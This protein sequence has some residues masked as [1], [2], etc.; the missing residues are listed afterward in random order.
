MRVLSVLGG[1]AVA[2]MLFAQGDRG[3]ITG[4]VADPG[5]AVVPNA[6]IVAVNE[7]NGEQFK[8]VTTPTGNYTLTQLPAGVYDVSVEVPG[9]NKFIQKGI[10]VF[11]AETARVDVTMKV[12]AATDSVTVMADAALLKTESAEQ[13]STIAVETLNDLPINFGAGGNSSAAGVRNALTLVALVPT[14]VFS[15]YSSVNLN[16]APQNSFNIQIEGMQAN[17]SRLAIRQ[18]QVQP[19]VESLQEVSVLTSN[20]APEYGQ[21]AGGFFNYVVKSGN[22]QVHGSLFEYLVNEDL[23]AGIP[24]TSSGVGGHLLRPPN[25]RDDF[26][27]N[28]GGPV[29][30][31]KLYNGRN[32]T[33]F[34]FSYEEFYQSQGVTGLSNVPTAAMR[35]GDFSGSLTGKSLGSTPTGAAILENTIY[36]PTSFT[37]TASGQ[38]VTDPF[39]NNQIPQSR[40]DRVALK[41]Q[42][43]LPLP[44]GPGVL[45]NWAQSYTALT[46][47]YIPSLKIDQS[48]NNQGKLSFYWSQYKGPHY[49]GLDGLP[50]PITQQRF[51]QTL[52]STYRLNYD[53]P[54]TPTWLVHL[55]VGYLDHYNTDCGLPAVENYDPVAGLGLVGAVYGKGFPAIS[56]LNSTNGGGMALGIGSVNCQPIEVYKPT[57][58]ASS[59]L[60]RGNHTFKVGGDWRI[61]ALTSG[62]SGA[63]GSYSFSGAQTGLPYT[64]GQT[65]GGSTV[66]LPYASF[67]L[68]LVNTASVSN[69]ALPQT[70]KASWAGYLQDNW[71]VT[72]KLTLDYG[73]RY[74]LQG[75]GDEFHHRVS[76]FSASIPNPSAGGL[77][78]AT[79]YEGSSPGACNCIFTKPYPYAFGPRFGVAY[80]IAPK[81]VLRGGFGVTYAQTG[82]GQAT[83]QA[84][85]GAG[86]WNTLAFSNPTYGSPASLL[87]NGLTYNLS[88]L[89]NST[90]NAGV[91]PQPGQIQSPSAEI[92]H[93]AGRPPRVMQWNVSLQR[94]VTKDLLI[95][96]AYVGNRGV[97]LEQDTQEN[98]NALTPARL[99]TFGLDIT[100]AANRTLL[101]STVAS[102]AVVAAGF[103]APYAGFPTTQTLAQALRPYPQ[104][105]TISVVGAALGRSWF[106]SL[107]MKLT[108]RLS[109]GLDVQSNFVWLKNE[110][111]ANNNDISNLPTQK[112]ITSNEQPFA[113]VVALN[114]QLPV[115][116]SNRFLR[117]VIRDWTLSTIVK[118]STG[119]PIPTPASTNNL[120]SLLFQT[121]TV[122]RVPGV[123]LFLQDL[124]C[125]CIDPYQNLVL[126]PAA[127]AQPAAGQFGTAAPYYNDFRYER[128]PSEQASLGRIFR[129]REKMSLQIR[130]EFFNIFNRTY[131]NNPVATNPLAT[132]TH[133]AAGQLTGGFGYINPGTVEDNP[134]SGQ[135][136][137]RFRF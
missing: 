98:L 27:G 34:F 93:N 137:A 90:L 32:K 30:I 127:W 122:N 31:P 20:F 119:L 105:S 40:F 37:T 35:N 110:G 9:F 134:R 22:N 24:F 79:V 46:K 18:D 60:S 97:W 94:E 123:P 61:D 47:E 80:Q 26:G 130:A 17:N 77:L 118:Y 52:T 113:L 129:I 25:R 15:G 55:G 12:G 81:T 101:T 39:P 54:L 121:A 128:R 13:S 69:P 84:T 2:T 6:A 95:E 51:I 73:L 4:T 67:L 124:N 59:S 56:G 58:V 108:K 91:R 65:I 63:Y 28:V 76:A 49:N 11:V 36:D 64:Q 14:G 107:Q 117:A 86:G 68:G 92:D 133:N 7:E 42:A 100:N 8:V 53:Q 120:S 38:V 104:F 10:R 135:I 23:G 57:A 43:L 72:R 5:G 87:K 85:L 48:F 82:G 33:F 96:A 109:H 1:L 41:I 132:T 21:V 103:K 75:A 71:K 44:T 136:V 3:V 102:A 16:G 45:N 99:A 70:R 19:S 125:H 116:S 106:D 29:W 83:N 114:Y 74:D 78:G 115:V 111:S 66:G 131:I 126:N 62:T 112:A 88:D 89:F 50:V